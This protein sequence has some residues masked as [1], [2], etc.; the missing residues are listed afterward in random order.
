MTLNTFQASPRNSETSRS[1]SPGHTIYTPPS[2]DPRHNEGL[3][4]KSVSRGPSPL[5]SVTFDD[6]TFSH[7]GSLSSE[8]SSLGKDLY[9]EGRISGH[10]EEEGMMDA[11][12]PLHRPSDGRSEV[13]LLKDERGRASFTE[14]NG[15]DRSTFATHR[16]T[17]RSRSPDMEGSAATKRKYIYA[18]F[19]LVLSLVAFVIQTETA[20]Y[21]QNKLGWKKPYAM[22]WKTPWRAFW[23]RHKYVVRSTA[24]MVVSKDLHLTSKESHESPVG[25]MLRKTA[26]VTTALTVAGGSWYYA[27]GMTTGSDLT[28]IYNCSAFFAYAFSIPLLGDKLRFDKV[29]AVVVAVAGVMTIAYGDSKQSEKSSSSEDANNRAVGN[30]VIGIGSVLYGLYE[31]LYK[32]LACPPEGAWK[33]LN[34]R[35]VERSGCCSSQPFR[36]PAS[37]SESGNKVLTNAIAVFSGAFLVLISLTS[38]VLSSVAGLLTIFLVCIA[39]YFRTGDA[40]SAA[41]IGGGILIMGAFFLLSWSTYREMEEEREKQLGSNPILSDEEDE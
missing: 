5:R 32:K 29:F 4:A 7:R 26:L 33:S 30:V 36:M 37:E 16:S 27:V 11:R 2:E 39:D 31:V 6:P 14:P 34:G 18:A 20:E 10:G 28:A 8:T 13:P 25:Y 15:S 21:I 40:L 19:F 17:F 22:L 9:E 12:P 41:A 38:P 1:T 23:R 24:Q 35:L 3:A